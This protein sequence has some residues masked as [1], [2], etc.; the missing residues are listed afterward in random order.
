MSEYEERLR[1]GYVNLEEHWK[2]EQRKRELSPAQVDASIASE[3]EE[4]KAR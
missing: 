3:I 1:R 4:L 2:D